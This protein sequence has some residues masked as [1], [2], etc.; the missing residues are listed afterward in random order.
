MKAFTK[1]QSVVL[2]QNLNTT[3]A[4]FYQRATVHSCGEKVLKLVCN[5]TGKMW[6]RTIYLHTIEQAAIRPL[7]VP[8]VFPDMADADLAAKCLEIAEN[9][10]AYARA[11][12]AGCITDLKARGAS[13]ER[14]ERDL[15]AIGE[16]RFYP[17][18]ECFMGEPK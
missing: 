14:C 7:H 8:A 11:H 10:V 6:G 12:L 17:Y 16:P 15:A 1:G 3:G 2:I 18:A 13:T 9:I 4:V 5:D